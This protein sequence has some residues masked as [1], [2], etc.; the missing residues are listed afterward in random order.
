M[1]IQI[2]S[3][4]EA[5]YEQVDQLFAS[6]LAHHAALLPHRF[7]LADPVMPRQWFLDVL[8]DPNKTLFVALNE[9]A[10]AG[11]ILLVESFSQDDPIYRPRHYLYVDEL[12]VQPQYRRQGIG[13][14]L[15]DSAEELAAD[16]NIPTIE[17]NVWQA[18]TQALTF[19]E[20]LGYHTIRRRLARD[21]S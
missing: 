19:Y 18:N 21:L 20:R 7:Q 2:R 17:L 3:A 15:M 16:R 14:R 6:E 5:D 13:R 11:L 12:A 9:S 1:H 4:A 8:A 10:I